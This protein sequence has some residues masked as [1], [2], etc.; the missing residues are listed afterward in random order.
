MVKTFRNYSKGRYTTSKRRTTFSV[1]RSASRR[2]KNVYP[3]KMKIFRPLTTV[4]GIMTSFQSDPRI[5]LGETADYTHTGPGSINQAYMF[6]PLVDMNN[7]TYRSTASEANWHS[8]HHS[9]LCAIYNEFE[10]ATTY[11]S[12][13]MTMD[14]FTNEPTASFLDNINVA[15]AI[16]P[17]K[18]LKDTKFVAHAP[19]Q[20]GRLFTGVDYYSTMTQ[21]P[22]TK[23]MLLGRNGN[24]GIARFN[25]KVDAYAHNGHSI[26][27]T[28]RISN[29]NAGTGG[30]IGPTVANITYPDLVEEQQVLLLAFRYV[31]PRAEDIYNVLL[32]IKCDQHF[33]YKDKSPD[34]QYKVYDPSITNNIQPDNL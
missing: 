8:P 11:V 4:Q 1:K 23:H 29:V 7:K 26:S 6:I 16:V 31:Q 22:N 24:N 28:S 30:I 3:V 12:G 32:A 2:P 13:Q 34:Y 17:F 10:Y 27:G 9:A 25:F 15:A 5:L 19:S 14:Y 33:L 21:S 20:F 18:Y